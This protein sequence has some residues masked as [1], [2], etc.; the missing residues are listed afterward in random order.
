MRKVLVDTNVIVSALLF[1][2]SV[3][4]RAFWHA[5]AHDDLVLT[6]WILEELR[7]VIARKIPNRVDGLE[8]VLAA[9]QFGLLD[10]A[11]SGIAMRD[12]D[13]Q[14]ILDA[15]I[16]GAVDIIVTGDKDFLSLGLERPRIL[17]PR[18]FLE[19]K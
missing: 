14:P 2:E 9:A 1:P 3:P 8:A 11:T 15:A 19:I 13:D 6:K 4:A 10:V 12:V 5:E 16:A 17:T 7:E 18:A